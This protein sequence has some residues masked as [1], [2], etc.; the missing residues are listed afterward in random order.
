MTL[1][2]QGSEGKSASALSAAW[3]IGRAVSDRR[4]EELLGDLEE[5]FHIQHLERGRRE[6]RRWYWRQAANAV[7]DAIRDRRRQPKPAAGDSLM[8]TIT[9]DLRYAF[10]SLKAN[11]GFATVAVLMLA[12]GIGA[13]ST[14]FSWVN[15]VLLDPMPGSA[16]TKELVQFTYLYKGDVM[17]SF[18]YPDYQDISRAAKQVTGITGW[19]DLSV[20]VIVDRDAER[21]WAEIV[22]SNFFDVHR[23]A[24]AARPR[25]LAAGRS[26]QAA[27]RPWC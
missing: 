22:T 5:L 8:Q 6:A 27:R 25:F 7:V 3:L 19:D 17:P 26:A 15:S 1:L 18:S 21:A 23:R 12:L 4:R 16:R 2:R 11:P 14:I 13:N 10:R 24:G 20:G 9:Q